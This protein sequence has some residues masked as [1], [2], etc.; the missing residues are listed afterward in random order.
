MAKRVCFVL[1]SC[2]LVVSSLPAETLQPDSYEPYEAEEFAP[3]MHTARRMETL[4][5]GSLPIT[6]AAAN[7]TSALLSA[8]LPDQRSKVTV[9]IGI[10]AGLSAAIVIID[11]ILGKVQ[12]GK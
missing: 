9:Q 6:F 4:F 11:Y 2:L 8:Q 3:W 12:D 10:T 5:F 7:L 1:L